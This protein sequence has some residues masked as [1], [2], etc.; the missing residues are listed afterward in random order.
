MATRRRSTHLADGAPLE[1]WLRRARVSAPTQKGYSDAVNALKTTHHL[2]DN[3]TAACVDKALDKQLVARFLAGRP[4]SAARCLYYGVRLPFVLR[5]SQLAL[6]HASLTGLV[7]RSQDTM[8]DP[9]AWEATLLT[10]LSLLS[11]PRPY[12][13]SEA[14]VAAAAVLLQFDLYAL[15]TQRLLPLSLGRLQTLLAVARQRAGLPPAVLHRL[16][17]GGPSADALNGVADP[18]LQRRGRW[19]ALKSVAR[20]PGRYLREL[21]QLTAAP[22]RQAVE[23]AANLVAQLVKRLSPL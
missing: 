1:G 11:L 3:S 23:A 8:R 14:A 20:K 21:E 12:D 9:V 10:A 5:D 16:R 2:T 7:R 4:A 6:A 17:H 15:P 22:K 18:V 19:A 13:P